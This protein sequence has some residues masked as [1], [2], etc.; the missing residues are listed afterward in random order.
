MRMKVILVPAALFLLCPTLY[1]AEA[2]FYDET[3]LPV[4]QLTFSQ[5]DWWSQLEANAQTDRNIPATLTVDGRIYEGVGVRFRGMTSYMTTRDSQKKSFNIEIDDTVEDQRLMGYKTLNLI[6]CNADPTFMREVLYSNV[7]RRQVPSAKANFVRL[8]INGENW[9]IYANVQQINAELI[10]DWFASNDGT[11]WR[12]EGG[13]GGGASPGDGA[14]PGGGGAVRPVPTPRPVGLTGGDVVVAEFPGGGGF[15]PGGGGFGNGSAA[16]TWQGADP[17]AYEAVYELKNTKQD[18]PWASL[19][20]TCDV[21]NNTTLDELPDVL[22]TV[23][24]MDR[25]LW[26]CAFEIVFQD[27][28]GYIFKRGSDYYLYYEPETGRIHLIQHDGNECMGMDRNQEWSVFYRADDPLVPLMYRLMAVGQYRQRYLAH[29]R[30]ILTSFLTEETLFPKIDAY[31]ALIEAEVRLDSKKLYT[32]QAFESGMEE[33]KDFVRNR[34]VSLLANREVSQPAPEIVTVDH[35][36]VSDEA[37]ETLTVT[38]TIGGSVG[39]SDVRLFVADG[40]FATFASVPMFDD[41]LH[42]DG[43]ASDGVFGIMLSGYPS[44]TLLRY[45]V[46][47]TADNAVG[48]LAFDPEGAETHVYMHLVSYAQAAYSAVVLNELMARNQSALANPQGE[49]DDWIELANVS[50]HIVDLSGMYLSD[51]PDNPLKWRLPDGVQIEPGA[52]LLVWADEDGGDEP[53]LHANFRLSAHG[54]TIWLFDTDERNHTL[55]DSVTFPSLEAD[56]SY[57]RHPDG[58]GPMLVLSAPSPL[59]ANAAPA[60]AVGN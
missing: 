7:C 59:A 38:A 34:R 54:E 16:L 48:T 39:V 45:Y 22:D 2:D 9:G 47:A 21:L 30:T 11:R 57:G 8:E 26:L 17:A 36:L 12:A 41:G 24:N 31:R 28:D 13:F 4:L 46:Q 32:Y 50:D 27:E 15:T 35:E 37:G 58:E 51:N 6:N 56:Q 44:G 18:D 3:V 55:L 52:Y 29:V 19:I 14:P 10:R 1:A 49:Y 25:A 5:P 43:D 33:L 40:A 23:L 20:H 60:A 53:G 42:G